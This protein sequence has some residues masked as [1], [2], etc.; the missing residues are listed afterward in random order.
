LK[1][2]IASNAPVVF[3]VCR[4]C[5]RMCL[6]NMLCLTDRTLSRRSLAPLAE[7]AR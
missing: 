2:P 6:M 7:N 1:S 4:L 5:F 3:L